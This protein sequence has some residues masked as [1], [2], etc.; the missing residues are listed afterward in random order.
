MSD[1]ANYRA[2]AEPPS[3]GLVI[4]NTYRL[5]AE[6][7]RGGVGEV[8]EAEHT[9][10]GKRVAIK[11]VRRSLLER[12]R[13]FERFRREAR[14]LSAIENEH[15]VC[16]FDCGELD[17]ATPYLV[18]ERLLG[19]D[20]SSLL[21]RVGRLPIG[22]A[23]HIAIDACRGLSAVHRAGFVHRDVKPAN[24]FLV[25]RA[26]GEEC[27]KLLDFGIAKLASGDVTLPG[28]LVGTVRYMAPEQLK[29]SAPIGA[30]TDLYAV[31]AILYQAL[32]GRAP[33]EAETL[34]ELMFEIMTRPAPDVRRLRS[35]VP[36]ELSKLIERALRRDAAQR[37]SSASEFASAL[38]Q[39][40]V[41][42]SMPLL[43]SESDITLDENAR[44]Q[45]P[46]ARRSQ[47][48]KRLAAGAL[49]LVALF[50]S[51]VGV[52]R[53]LGAN[54]EPKTPSRIVSSSRATPRADSPNDEPPAEGWAQKAEAPAMTAVA[55]PSG[56]AADA[57]PVCVAKRES[58]RIREVNR[59]TF[60]A[61][62]QPRFDT[63][64][65]YA[66]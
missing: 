49:S 24:L 61:V 29:N 12:A 54:D 26:N 64:N 28:T 39:F 31:G 51:G 35:E 38:E 11:F 2:S 1:A 59:F 56:R 42:P 4:A 5:V 10:L 37:I 32:T 7:G 36:N 46:A 65:P 63:R 62:A 25:R 21:A 14:A 66:D 48:R 57:A 50:A 60:P 47:R 18:M 6:L 53:L 8:W 16:A 30:A 20:L 15:V 3:A 27:C 33:H 44:G 34:E 52:G 19:E 22:R 55:E 45:I 41:P 23:V 9:R 13:A 40:A 58:A 43:V 17:G